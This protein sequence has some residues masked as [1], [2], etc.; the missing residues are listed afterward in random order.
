VQPLFYFNPLLLVGASSYVQSKAP[1][2]RLYADAIPIELFK[3]EQ[4]KLAEAIRAI[5][6]RI[7]LQ[8]EQSGEEAPAEKPV[9]HTFAKWGEAIRSLKN[10]LQ[11]QNH[12]P[13]FLGMVSVRTFWQPTPA[14][15]QIS[16]SL[17]SCT[18]LYTII[19]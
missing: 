19:G 17:I 1:F 11:N 13:N 3:E 7:Q 15:K 16:G 4:R 6:Q 5:D 2:H 18:Y 14:L 8:G 9:S 10:F 12:A